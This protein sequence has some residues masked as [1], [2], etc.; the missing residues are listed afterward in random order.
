ML[1]RQTDFPARLA[2]ATWEAR[3]LPSLIMRSPSLRGS[4]NR[5]G[6]ADPG[7]NNSVSPSHSFFG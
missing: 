6:P 5:F 2:S 4:V 3:T 7:L 1:A